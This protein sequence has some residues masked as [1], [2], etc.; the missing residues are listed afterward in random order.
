[1]NKADYN[2]V[3]FGTDDFAVHVLAL[4]INN[5]PLRWWRQSAG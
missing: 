2:F 3:F 1:M 4:S 5:S